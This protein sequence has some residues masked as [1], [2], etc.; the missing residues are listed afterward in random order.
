MNNTVKGAIV[1]AGI[2]LAGAF[3]GTVVAAAS[4]KTTLTVQDGDS[5]KDGAG[6]DSDGTQGSYKAAMDGTEAG[7]IMDAVPQDKAVT[8]KK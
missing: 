7:P 1:V 2:V 3:G 8:G 6:I 5:G 4:P